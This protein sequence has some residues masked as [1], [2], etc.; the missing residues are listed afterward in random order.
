MDGRRVPAATSLRLTGISSLPSLIIEIFIEIRVL[1]QKLLQIGSGVASRVPD[2]KSVGR[3]MVA[4]CKA[5]DDDP[6]LASVAV[7]CAEEN[8]FSLLQSPVDGA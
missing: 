4:T 6:M 1:C 3:Q 7:G 8:G 2:R 5:C